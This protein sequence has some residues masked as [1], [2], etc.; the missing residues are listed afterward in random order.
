[1]PEVVVQLS[2]AVAM[3]VF[4]GNKEAPQFTVIAVGTLST[5]AS[6]SSTVT[7]CIQVLLL[8]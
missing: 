5:G 4:D 3:P 6:L 8:P 7:V 2:V 1:M